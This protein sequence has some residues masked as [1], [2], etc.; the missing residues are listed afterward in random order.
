MADDSPFIWH[1]LVTEDQGAGGAFFCGLFGWTRRRVDAGA[2]R[3]PCQAAQLG[4]YMEL[5]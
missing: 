2:E 4:R 5:I 1:E 3:A